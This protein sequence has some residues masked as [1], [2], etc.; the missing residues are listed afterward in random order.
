VGTTHYLT[1]FFGS[2]LW[3]FETIRP[4]ISC[5]HARAGLPLRCRLLQ[6]IGPCVLAC[7]LGRGVASGYFHL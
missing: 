2:G 6:F 3:V 1:P 7:I 4:Q 5:L